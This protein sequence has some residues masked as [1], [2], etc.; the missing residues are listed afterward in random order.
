MI[1][2]I[3]PLNLRRS[4]LYKITIDKHK[5]S[6]KMVRQK[7]TPQMKVQEKFAEN[8]KKTNGIEAIKPPDTEFKTVAIGCTIYLGKKWMISV[9][10]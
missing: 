6:D 5:K 3:A 9:R 4:L 10:I 1:I 2:K 7:N 8:K